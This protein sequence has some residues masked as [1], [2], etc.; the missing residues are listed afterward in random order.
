VNEIEHLLNHEQRILP[1]STAPPSTP[2]PSGTLLLYDRSITRNYKDDGHQWIK[3]RNSH[4]VREDHVKLRVGGKFRVSGCYVHS[5]NMPSFHR[6]AYHLLCPDTGTA[7]YPVTS[8]SKNKNRIP[9]L[10]L[11]HYLDTKIAGN[12]CTSLIKQGIEVNPSFVRDNYDAE[13]MDGYDHDY[14]DQPQVVT[15]S[16]GYEETQY[17]EVQL[18]AGSNFEASLDNNTLDFLWDVVLEEGD[19]DV[20]MNSSDISALL[21]PSMIEKLLNTEGLLEDGTVVDF[22]QS[23]VDLKALAETLQ[24]LKSDATEKGQEVE[25]TIEIED[26]DGDGNALKPGSTEVHSSTGSSQIVF[27]AHSDIPS[28]LDVTPESLD[29]SSSLAKIVISAS[30]VVPS[31][32]S[33]KVWHKVLAFVHVTV[34][35]KTD[36]V[37]VKVDRLHDIKLLNPYTSQCII[38]PRGLTSGKYQAIILGL[39]LAYGASKSHKDVRVA[40]GKLLSH[41]AQKSPGLFQFSRQCHTISAENITV[42]VLTQ[43]SQFQISCTG[44]GSSDHHDECSGSMNSSSLTEHILSELPAPPPAMALVATILQDFP[45]PPPEAVFSEAN[46]HSSETVEGIMNDSLYAS[47]G[48]NELACDGSVGGHTNHKRKLS[49]STNN[50]YLGAAAEEWALNVSEA[51]NADTKGEEVDR[52]CKIR[53]VERLT[54]VIAETGAGSTL[55]SRLPSEIIAEDTSSN[56]DAICKCDGCN[57]FLYLCVL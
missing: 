54:S 23:E 56:G 26:Y 39:C 45:N 47:Q 46:A 44:V 12:H 9:S 29:V 16:G 3:K 34:D 19:E 4:K 42:K 22:D 49:H 2:P 53:F 38:P 51:K 28:I 1:L 21:H 48:K 15:S 52:H 41:A 43:P 57:V 10:V 8:A 36:T 32:P 35:S 30:S 14:E 13:N 33:D 27:G 40:V 7:L 17:E 31:L 37:D 11:V 24:V 50:D 6:R 5:N 25:Y 20:N 55:K 18:V